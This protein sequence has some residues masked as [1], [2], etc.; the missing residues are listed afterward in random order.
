[1]I[2]DVYQGKIDIRHDKA[3]QMAKLASEMLKKKFHAKKVLLFGSVL[4]KEYFGMHS[5]IDLAVSGI[6]DESFYKAVGETLTLVS[7]FEVDIVDIDDC[8]ESIKK[9]IL[10]EGVQI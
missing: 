6:P 3:V 4:Y 9:V 8:R 2:N 1:M 5:D 7:P 10:N